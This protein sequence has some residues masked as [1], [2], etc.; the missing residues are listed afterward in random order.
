MGRPRVH[1]PADSPVHT[2]VTQPTVDALDEIAVA[3]GLTALPPSS[4]GRSSTTSP[5]VLAP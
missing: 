5:A 3:E 2:Y 4:G 1:D